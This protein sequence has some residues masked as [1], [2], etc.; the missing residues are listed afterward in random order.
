[1]EEKI[2]YQ[3]DYYARRAQEEDLRNY[4]PSKEETGQE[5]KAFMRFMGNLEEAY[6]RKVYQLRQLAQSDIFQYC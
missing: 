5:K 1:M 4:V 6:Y 2:I 3:R